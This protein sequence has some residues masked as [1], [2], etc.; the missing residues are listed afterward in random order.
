MFSVDSSNC[1]VDEKLTSFVAFIPL[2][3]SLAP[4]VNSFTWHS[5]HLSSVFLLLCFRF[6]RFWKCSF[7]SF[8]SIGHKSGSCFRSSSLHSTLQGPESLHTSVT[9]ISYY[10]LSHKV[11]SYHIMLDNILSNSVM[12][13]SILSYYIV[14]YWMILYHTMLLLSFSSDYSSICSSINPP[15]LST[16]F[17]SLILI[18]LHILLSLI[19][20]NSSFFLG[21]CIWFYPIRWMK[22]W[23]GHTYQILWS[24][25]NFIFGNSW[26]PSVFLIL[27]WAL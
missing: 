20:P 5:S 9:L 13:Y 27:R 6:N 23:R 21:S 22:T 1:Q 8:R 18:F 16:S 2:L 10:I 14:S 17:R 19:V 25:T 15:S 7:Y 3:I 11:I 26:P 12:S 24:Q 4:I